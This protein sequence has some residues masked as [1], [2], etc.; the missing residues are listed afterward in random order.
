MLMYGMQ[1]RSKRQTLYIYNL[2]FVTFSRLFVN[3]MT[4]SPIEDHS[5]LAAGSTGTGIANLPN[6]RHK[7]VAKRGTHF[8]LMVCGKLERERARTFSKRER[9]RI[10]THT[11]T[12][13]RVWCRKNDIC[14]YPLHNHH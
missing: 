11:E 9:V 2:S 3:T 1:A 12:F 13:R 4:A 6:Q 5:F 8:T 10:H 14:Q 7:I